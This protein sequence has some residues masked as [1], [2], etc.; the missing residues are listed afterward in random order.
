M[1][2]LLASDSSGVEKEPDPIEALIGDL[3]DRILERGPQARA[4]S[5]IDLKVGVTRARRLLTAISEATGVDLP[6]TVMFQAPTVAA[7]AQLVREGISPAQPAAVLLQP[8]DDATPLF[9]FAGVGGF[10]L[11]LYELGRLIRPR[12]PVYANLYRGLDGK[13]PLQ[14]SVAEMARYQSGVIRAIQPRGPYCLAGFSLGGLVALETARALVESGEKVAFVG[15]MEPNLPERLWPAAVKRAFI[16][17]R[18][19]SHLKAMAA[20]SPREI[21]PYVAGRVAPLAARLRRLFGAAGD[22]AASPYTRADLPA[23]L[24]AAR[25]AG[26]AAYYSYEI[27]PYAGKVVFFDSA[28]GDPLSCRPLDVFPPYV[29]FH[30]AHVCGGEHATMLRQPHVAELARQMSDVLAGLDLS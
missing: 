14:R 25:E 3:W 2:R 28:A 17:R 24:A 16:W 1:T 11:E 30:E 10:I 19:R 4:A 7:L 12:G 20:L 26:L 27:R 9:L 29:A 21:A 23:D 15:L 13:Q 18:I 5:L 22:E 6:V 8:S